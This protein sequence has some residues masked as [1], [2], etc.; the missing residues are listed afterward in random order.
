MV[1]SIVLGGEGTV[2]SR[3]GHLKLVA[4][5]YF[6]GGLHTHVH[7]TAIFD[8]TAP[9]VGGDAKFGVDEVPVVLHESVDSVGR[10]SLFI[11]SQ[12]ENHVSHWLE[13]IAL[14]PQQRG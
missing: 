11:R 12:D 9:A 7:P 3:I 2:A 5:K 1:N 14:D 8:V 6:L 10:A 13:S 4:D